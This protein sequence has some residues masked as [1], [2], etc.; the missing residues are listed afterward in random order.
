MYWLRIGSIF[1][2]K[3]HG[4]C[5]KRAPT[6][7]A[8]IPLPTT[9]LTRYAG[10]CYA[11]SKAAGHA[12]KRTAAQK[13]TGPRPLRA[14]VLA[15]TVLSRVTDDNGIYLVDAEQFY[16][17]I[18]RGHWPTGF[19]LVNDEPDV[20]PGAAKYGVHGISQC[21]FEPVAPRLA[22]VLHVADGWF[23][24]ASAHDHRLEATR[25]AGVLT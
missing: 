20:V 16:F 17:S 7:S 4:W 5:A 23:D 3:P 10:C 2:A 19:K 13:R 25:D 11:R 21:P 1:L 12:S 9:R 8:N 14:Q 6:T 18:S 15:R 24:S 22:V